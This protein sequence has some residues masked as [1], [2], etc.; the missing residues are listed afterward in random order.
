VSGLLRGSRGRRGATTVIAEVA[1]GGLVSLVSAGTAAAA[2]PGQNGDIAFASI[3]DGNV[4]V[5]VMNADG[6]N[7]TNL[8]N[9]AAF[10]SMPAW[11]PDGKQIAFTSFRDG[12]LEVYVMD[13]DGSNPT[14]L[15]NH[16]ASDF[17]PDWRSEGDLPPELS[18]RADP[19]QL[20]PPNRKLVPVS[21]Q[22]VVVDDAD[23]APQVRL[24]SI[25]CT[26]GCDP[27]SDVSDAELGEDDRSFALRAHLGR[28]P[29]DLR[30][31]TATY[32]AT[33][34]TGNVTTAS[35]EIPVSRLAP[36]P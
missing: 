24:E 20:W 16:A 25:T 30:V 23:P 13:A 34:A 18:L 31:Y 1:L 26:G 19:L 10:D 36:A 12:N 35:V 3:R 9:D 14:N 4:E 28:P 27:A 8:T 11:S 29:N 33:D 6:S 5:Y 17:T 2:F 15:T 22:V 21:I 32:S 7:P